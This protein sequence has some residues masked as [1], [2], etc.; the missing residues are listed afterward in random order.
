[1]ADYKISSGD[2]LWNIAKNNYDCKSNKEILET[3]N[4]IA[5]E[6][7][8]N[9]NDT[10]F[11]GNNLVLPETDKIKAKKEEEQDTF[12]SSKSKTESFDEWSNSEEN[13]NKYNSG[14]KVEDFKMFDFNI[15][16]YI[17][18]LDNFAKD[19]I[20]QTDVDNDGKLNLNEFIYMA[21]NGEQNPAELM[22][23]KQIYNQAVKEFKEQI[24]PQF[25]KDGNGSLNMAEFL[26][27]HKSELTGKD[28]LKNIAA[29][30]KDFMA[31]NT[32]ST[33]D[34]KNFE[35]SAEEMFVAYNQNYNGYSVQDLKL[36]SDTYDMYKGLK[37]DLDISKDGKIDSGEWASMLYVAD[38]GIENFTKTE[39][40]E[41]CVDGKLDYETY[42]M[43]PMFEKGTK[44]Y[45]AVTELKTDLY[46]GFYE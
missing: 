40:L 23:S 18:D 1:M 24:M 44:A 5:K 29:L 32:D 41:N 33:E 14:E 30:A 13:Y 12:V 19:Y 11:A 16:T 42:Q 7:K 2:C 39:G 4:L 36:A 6:N 22:N 15:D 37:E 27:A 35:L 46:K 10:I 8:M 45:E 17:E 26:S 38:L 31:I 9:V 43:M 25:D 21:T 28:A 20:K 3:V 34:N